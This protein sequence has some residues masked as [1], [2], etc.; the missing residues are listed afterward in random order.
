MTAVTCFYSRMIYLMHLFFFRCHLND[1]ENVFPFVLVGLLYVLTKPDPGTAMMHFRAF[2]GFRI[3]H[4]IAY[5]VPLPQPSRA[6][7]FLLGAAVTGSMAVSV[8]SAGSY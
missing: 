3:F 1:L 8:L 7:G 6:L 2:A 4:T 5:L